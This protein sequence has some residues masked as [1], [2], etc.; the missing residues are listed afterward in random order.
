M[1]GASKWNQGNKKSPTEVFQFYSFVR[2]VKCQQVPP[3]SVASALQVELVRVRNRMKELETERRFFKKKFKLLLSRLSEEKASWMKKEQKK[4]NAVVDKLTDEL[5]RERRNFQ[6]MDIINSKLLRDLA[7]AK[8]SVGQ[9]IGDYQKE[10]KAREL[11]EDVCNELVKEI[12]DSNAMV[13]SMEIEYSRIQEEVVEERKMLQMAEV[14][15]EERVQMKLVDAKLLLEEKYYQM[16]TIIREL[17]TF[18][19]T[20]DATLDVCKY[21]EAMGIK[22]ATDAIDVLDTKELRYTPPKSYDIYTIMEDVQSSGENENEIDQCL[23]LS[24]ASHSSKNQKVDLQANE[25]MQFSVCGHPSNH[26]DAD[27]GSGNGGVRGSVNHGQD[28]KL[29]E[30]LSSSEDFVNGT[31][32]DRY[33]SS[34]VTDPDQIENQE[35]LNSGTNTIS[36][37]NK[38]S[39][40]RKLWRSSISSR[41]VCETVPLDANQ[42]LSSASKSA[43]VDI[44][45]QKMSREGPLKQHELVTQWCSPGLINP[46]ISRAMKGCIEWPRGIQRSNLKP[47]LLEASLECHKRRMSNV[48]KQRIR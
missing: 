48:L 36:S 1:E 20:S 21:A 29:S 19:R 15:R 26:F 31:G 22:Q 46:H 30:S 16:N 4:V 13:K 14:W 12:E 37:R 44:S 5:K 24:P 34:V 41:S 18:L 32:G 25:L 6:K 11:L 27:W 10:R 3:A 8:L 9:L 40:L 39:S 28:K 47:K 42:R 43:K 33:M 45:P 23:R 17:E 2:Q 35:P 38:G 7:D